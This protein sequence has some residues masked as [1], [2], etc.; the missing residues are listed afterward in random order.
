M[1]TRK[2][3]G[4]GRGKGYSNITGK[5]P[6]VHSQSA[7]GIKQPQNIPMSSM[8]RKRIEKEDFFSKIM[9]EGNLIISGLDENM[10]SYRVF[11]FRGKKF[12]I[13]STEI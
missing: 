3:M 12:K 7:K 4:K 8:L 13:T 9:E 1:V 2:G 11:E 5:D 6:R 10:N